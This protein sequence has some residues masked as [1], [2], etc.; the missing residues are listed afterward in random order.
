L[1]RRKGYLIFTTHDGD[2]L[3]A[4]FITDK[5]LYDRLCSSEVESNENALD[6]WSEFENTP[7]YD[8][9]DRKTDHW[10]AQ[11]PGNYPWPFTDVEVLGTYYIL[12]Y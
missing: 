1:K 3:D 4:T 8:K 5:V 10:F 12:V 11:A 7:A 9:M 6:I 2:E